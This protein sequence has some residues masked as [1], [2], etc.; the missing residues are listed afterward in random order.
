[1]RVLRS[2][3]RLMLPLALLTP[4]R[5]DEQT[6]KLA[7]R[8][9]EEATAFARMAPQLVGQETLH[10]RAL[11]P[12]ARFRLRVGD[13]A[14]APP[15]PAWQERELVSEY[16]FALFSS[17]QAP[18]GAG[19]LHELRQVTSVDGHKVA[20]TG[21]AQEELAKA[22]TASGDARRVQML[23][24]FEKHGLLG[25]V[26]DLGQMLLLF[27]A[28]DIVR[29]E[30]SSLRTDYQGSARLLVFSYRQ[31]DGQELSVF[32]ERHG[33]RLRRMKV[34][35]EVWVRESNFTPVRITMAAS[36]GEG[37]TLI[38]EE[39]TVN[40]TMSTWGALVPQSA[41]HR[42][43][44]AGKLVT[45]N[46]F[47]YGAFQEFGASGDIQFDARPA[48]ATPGGPATPR[49]VAFPQR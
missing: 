34:F 12:A 38:R 13:A 23:K 30:F 37:P 35:G 40:Y 43:L 18:G 17:D 33:D 7:E 28:R 14:K 39:A 19:T 21:K 27:S 15:E 48:P 1:M 8:L 5:A 16:T 6:K 9:A 44:R 45:E 26:T 47:L 31:I 4:L 42:E 32:D 46:R 22:I 2:R 10:Q 3:C 29:Y 36:Q 41:E 20:E 11:K 49:A 24:D 25:A